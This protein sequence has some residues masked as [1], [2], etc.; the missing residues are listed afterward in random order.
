MKQLNHILHLVKAGLV[1]A[2]HD[3]LTK[4]QVQLLPAPARALF[5]LA[6][7]VAGKPKASKTSALN[8]A[9]NELGPSY[10]KLG[11]FLATR[12]DFIGK[13]RAR[14]L[15]QLQDRLA[16]FDHQV[17]IDEVE[18][19][20]GKKLSEVFATFSKPVAAASIAQVHKATLQDGTQLAVK[21][22]RP[23]VRRRFNKDLEAFAFA[24]RMMEKWI[25]PSRRLRPVEA[26][27]VLAKSIDL[28]MDLRMEAAA[29]AEMDEN[30]KD[31]ANFRVP[32][33]D[34]QRTTGRMLVMEWIDGIPLNA[35]EKLLAAGV[36]LEKL[37]KTVIQSFLRHAIRDGF[38][39]A[40]MHQGNLFVDQQGRLVAV[41]FGITGRLSKQDRFV[42]AQVLYGFLNKKYLEVAQAH[43]DAGY[44]PQTEDV[45]V[46]AQSLR[47][48]G[49]PIMDKPAEEISV[50]QLL[51]QLL[52]GTQRFNMATQPQLILLQK[53][54]VVV[55][56]VARSLDPKF[57]MWTASEPVVKEWLENRL[58][59]KGAIEDL[60]QGM[61]TL[62]KVALALPQSLLD[63][64]QATS[65][66]SEMVNKGQIGLDNNTTKNLAKAQSV[67]TRSTRIAL[68]V[69]ALSLVVIALGQIL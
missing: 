28:E 30:T 63:M 34:W 23:N 18:R 29:I 57:N 20:S 3:V 62:G 60:S 59:P 45:N 54:M 37:S 11:Q 46:F 53:T 24:A 49:E 32:K 52:E 2:R 5:K 7:L 43:F 69:G 40:D 67:Q 35:P 8:T 13:D 25:E 64:Q 38:F 6:K 16:P 33:V 65:A 15:A 27:R 56:G 26:I 31:D 36:D 9:L 42:L 39:H 22:L 21:I 68:W 50:G 17:A 19:Q 58:G 44:V 1:F 10:I 55:E 12:P 4:Q 66:L 51:G 14:E 61:S 41:D 47:A 48:I